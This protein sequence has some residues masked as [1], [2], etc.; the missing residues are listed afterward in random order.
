MSGTALSHPFVLEYLRE[1]DAALAG[2]PAPA[3]G[4]LRERCRVALYLD[5]PARSEPLTPRSDNSKRRPWRVAGLGEAGAPEGHR[6]SR[7]SGALSASQWF[8][9]LVTP[10]P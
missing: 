10:L 6:S 9:Q 3:A 1:L 7:A 2:L 4:E 8:A 5:F